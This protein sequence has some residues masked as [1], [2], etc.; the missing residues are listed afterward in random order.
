I[1][2][3]QSAPAVFL[4]ACVLLSFCAILTFLQNKQVAVSARGVLRCLCPPF[5][6]RNFNISSE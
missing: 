4:V 6:L 5:I 3:L 1:N 2:R